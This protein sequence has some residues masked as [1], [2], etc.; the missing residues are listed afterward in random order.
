MSFLTLLAQE[1]IGTI[2]GEKGF[3]PW[4]N[5]VKRIQ[6]AG[7]KVTPAATIFTDIISR[8]IGIMTIIAGI[9]FIFQFIIGAY[10]F[11]AA[12][13][14]PKA[15]ESA[16]KKITQAII[17]LVIVVAAWALISLIGQLLGFELILQPQKVIE[18][19]G[20]GG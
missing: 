3:G 11:L 6:E 18:M 14:D 5:I 15:I 12:S 2:G 1:D 8:I 19:L 4:G 13:G 20:P 7:G 16:T 9:W 10:G 17:G